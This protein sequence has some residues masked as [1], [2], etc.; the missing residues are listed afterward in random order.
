MKKTNNKITA[1]TGVALL[2]I[3]GA[4]IY[5]S[6]SVSESDV[7]LAQNAA[8]TMEGAVE[9]VSGHHQQVY[10]PEIKDHVVAKDTRYSGERDETVLVKVMAVS[11]YAQSSAYG[12]LPATLKGTAI[13]NLYVDA[14]GN[15]VIDRSA[16][17]FIEYFLTAAREEGNAQ[18][19]G[20]MQ[21]YFSMVLEGEAQAQAL[22]LL[23]NYM[24]YRQQLDSA[25]S[26]DDIVG[27][28]SAQMVALR[29]TLDRRKS[30]RRTSL[31][32]DAA[33]S[34]FGDSEKYEDYAVSMM[35]LRL[36]KNLSY[37]EQNTLTQHYEEKLPEHIKKRVRHE[38]HEKNL[39]RQIASLKEEGGKEAEI[40]DLRKSFYGEKTADRWAYMEGKSGDWQARTS[41]FNQTKANILA[42]VML[43][44]EQKRRQVDELRDL[45]FTK[46][47]KLKM[48]WQSLR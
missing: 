1:I 37:E 30:L 10:S 16:K 39:N 44:Y 21:E 34:M 26:R 43:T 23:E 40:Y 25:V 13:P 11:D 18:I 20:R 12:E 36:D 38:R 33:N 42:S 17:N 8:D 3:L 4:S 5:L 24:D 9:S 31:G 47:E 22:A 19:I 29:E 41:S 7:T 32:D 15:L 2:G 48:A 27:D 28:K 35:T 46:D 14:A 6:D 45:G